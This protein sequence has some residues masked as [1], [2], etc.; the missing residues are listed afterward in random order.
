MSQSS[1]FDQMASEWDANP[2]VKKLSSA[3]VKAFDSSFQPNKEMEVLELGT[4]TGLIAM[5]FQPMVKSIVAMD[6]SKGMI[7]MLEQKIKERGVKNIEPLYLENG[8]QSAADVGN[9]QFDVILSSMVL[10][11]IKDV[12]SQMKV[13]STILRPGGLLLFADLEKTEQTPEFHPKHMHA[14]VYHHGFD[15]NTLEQWLADAGFKNIS[16][17]R[18]I[19]IAK[20][21]ESGGAKDFGIFVVSVCR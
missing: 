12:A 2:F 5:H 9:R 17:K 10:H 16:I 14:D 18:D 13:L 19:T 8:I 7:D 15:A 3:V 4:G 6:T 1:R 20:D 21:V 11:H